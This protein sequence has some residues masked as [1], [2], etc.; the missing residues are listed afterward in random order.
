MDENIKK[1]TITVLFHRNKIIASILK[2]RQYEGH[3]GVGAGLW[4]HEM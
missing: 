4:E 2:Y 1:M 3:N